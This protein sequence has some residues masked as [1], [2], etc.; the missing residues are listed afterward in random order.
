MGGRHVGSEG[1]HRGAGPP[2]A[3]I[4]VAFCFAFLGITPAH[5]P[6]SIKTAIAPRTVNFMDNS[7]KLGLKFWAGQCTRTRPN[8]STDIFSTICGCPVGLGNT[9]GRL[10]HWADRHQ[11]Q[12]EMQP[13]GGPA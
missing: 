11:R 12:P 2:P 8:C 9:V 1:S 6:S 10:P 3:T 5:N 7:P 13:L 4:T